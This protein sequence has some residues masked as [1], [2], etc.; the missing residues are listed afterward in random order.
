MPNRKV[1]DIRIARTI[2]LIESNFAEDIDFNSLAES[3]NLSAPRLR[4]LFKEQTGM[5]FR[6]YLRLIRM[7]KAQYLL[8]T[9][10]FTVKEIAKQVGIHDSSNFVKDFEKQ[11][12]LSPTKYRNI[13]LP[14]KEKAASANYISTQKNSRSNRNG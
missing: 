8:E 11:F 6:K 12:G 7:K 9:T 14:R 4:Q 13:H 5:P 2:R 1:K 10:F 3:L